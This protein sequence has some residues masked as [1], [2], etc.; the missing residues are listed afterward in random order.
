M[1]QLHSTADATIQGL[2]L[3]IQAEFRLS[4]LFRDDAASRLMTELIAKRAIE[5]ANASREAFYLWTGDTLRGALLRYPKN[6]VQ[7]GCEGDE[8][9]IALCPNDSA[10]VE[11][12]RDVILNMSWSRERIT[13]GKISAY[14]HILVPTLYEVGLGID[15]LGLLGSTQSALEALDQ[16]QPTTEDLRA[17]GC[18]V[19]PLDLTRIDDVVA[20]RERTFKALPEYCWF[21]ANPGHLTAHRARLVS[22]I[23]TPHAWYVILKDSELVGHFGSAVTL[24]NPMWGAVGGLELYF[25]AELRGRGIA[26]FAYRH[27]LA[28][29]RAHGVL[30]FKGITAQPPVMHLSKMMGR[31]LFE[32]HLHNTPSFQPEHFSMYL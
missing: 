16:H 7:F 19:V 4:P 26:R 8:L 9:V 25:D 29:L 24:N 23:K 13:V 17:L 2:A 22:D 30:V 18:T 12:A 5:Q 3:L 10:A 1:I 28:T 6:F 27:T 32:I 31:R 21:G 11:W 15:A 20:L 14:H